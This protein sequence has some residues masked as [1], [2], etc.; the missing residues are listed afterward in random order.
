MLCRIN[1]GKM[2]IDEVPQDKNEL[3]EGVREIQYAVDNEGNYTQVL[4][5]G[6]KPKTDVLA[7][8]WEEIYKK[9]NNAK[10]LV[11]KNKKSPI[12]FYMIKN[13]MDINILSGYMNLSRLKVKRHLKAKN[14]KKISMEILKK[15]TEIFRLNDVE[16]LTNFTK[17]HK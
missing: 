17:Y 5:T 4:S 3:S 2:K 7:D 10:N 9:I 15:Y 11:L 12:Y 8:E 6:W 13:I 16:E 14:F 1:E